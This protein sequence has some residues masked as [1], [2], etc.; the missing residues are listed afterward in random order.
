MNELKTRP[1]EQRLI[2]LAAELSAPRV[3]TNTVGRGQFAAA[4]AEQNAHSQVTC[5]LLDLYQLNECSAFCQPR[6]PNLQLVCL[7]DPPAD[8]FDLVAWSLSRTGQAELTRE[9]LQIGYERLAIGGRFVA[10]I[11]N[12]AD[13]WLHEQLKRMFP[14]VTRRVEGRGAVYLATKTSPLKKRKEYSSELA[15]RDGERL[16]YVRT[17]PGVFSHRELDGGAR[18]MIKVMEITAG[19]RVLDLGCGS[20]AVGLAAAL[21]AEGVRVHAIDSNPRAVEAI[22]WG[23]ERNNVSG[24][25]AALDCDGTTAEPRAFDLVLANPPYFSNFRIAELFL[26][27]A[28]RAL[29]KGGKLLLVTKT[30]QWYAENMP[31]AFDDAFTQP[32]G[33]YVLVVARKA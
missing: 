9:M 23:A 30:P 25:T 5:W 33:N 17:R 32:A 4:F 6:R 24:L 27:I 7:A 18:A 19:M 2:D 1:Q 26:R 10:S 21:R 22:E 15:F 16:I 31:A 13:H 28:A 20:G 3:L 12:A 14:K 8:E 11:D 29:K